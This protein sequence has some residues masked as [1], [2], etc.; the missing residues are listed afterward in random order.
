M[1]KKRQLIIGHFLTL[2]LGGMIYISFRSAT[3]K[4]FDW[5]DT[6]NLLDTISNFRVFTLPFSVDLPNWFLYSLPDGL[7][8]FSYLSLLLFIWNNKISKQNMHWL[9][10]LPILAISSEIGQFFGI[11]PG[12][13]DIIDLIFY[14]AGS[15][16]PILFFTNL[17]PINY[18]EKIH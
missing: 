2:L 10:L 1:L 13:F 15:V 12:T 8:L 5:F 14:T 9:L 6:I 11:V 3:L 18:H 16:L 7:W 4:M 17:K